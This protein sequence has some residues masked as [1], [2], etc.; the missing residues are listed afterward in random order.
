MAFVD[1]T[2]ILNFALGLQII[3]AALNL[4]P[5]TFSIS[6]LRI[7]CRTTTTISFRNDEFWK[8]LEEANKYVMDFFSHSKN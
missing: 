4:S 3:G 6:W 8:L 5:I 1:E 2:F 7:Q